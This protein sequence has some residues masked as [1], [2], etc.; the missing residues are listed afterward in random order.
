MTEAILSCLLEKSLYAPQQVI[1]SDIS[2]QRLRTLQETYGIQVVEE[3]SVVFAL[4]KTIV[5]GIKPQALITLAQDVADQNISDALIISILAGVPL[6]RLE[7][8]FSRCPVI[9]VM[10]NTP[11]RVG[12]GISAIAGGTLVQDE[13]LSHAV[14]A[15]SGSGPAF[16]A[17][18]IE[19]LTD[20]GVAVG[21]PRP[22]AAQLALQT[23]RGTAELMVQQ[24]IHPALMKDQVTSPGGTT[25]AGVSTLEAAGFRSALI[26]AV[27]SAYQRPRWSVVG[28]MLPIE[29][30]SIPLTPPRNTA[31]PLPKLAVLLAAGSLSSATGA[32]IAPV[33]PEVIADLQVDPGW[34]GLLVSIHTLTT[35]LASPVFAL[36]ANR[37]GQGV[38]L[39]LSLVG[40]ACFGVAG[41]WM[42]SFG[43]MLA[44]RALVGMASG[45]IAAVSI[46]ILSSM[47]EGDARSRMLGY[48]TSAL[49]VATVIFPVLSG[50][51]GSAHWQYS[52]YLH[53]LALL[54]AISAMFIRWR[55]AATGSAKSDAYQTHGLL[56]SLQQGSTPSLLGGLLLT[57]AIFYV[58][59][60]YVPLHLKQVINATP[61]VSG[62]VIA[63]QAVGAAVI[64]AVGASRLAKRIGSNPAIALGFLL[65]ASSLLILPSLRIPGLLVLAAL[66]FGIGVGLAMPSFYG[67][68]SNGTPAHQR[69]SILAIGTGVSSLGHFISPL[70]FGPVWKFLGE[71]V[72]TVAA[73][74]AIGLSILLFWQNQPKQ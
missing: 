71:T 68:L 69:S 2:P 16:V 11:A 30:K 13:H 33:F 43:S 42:D 49:A 65:M 59:I 25:I 34:A 40:Y 57:S 41:A 36:L 18:A 6:Q 39:G 7:S 67:A 10:P 64:S 50:W 74:L 47:Y 52:F 61:L 22:V 8:I 73:G 38:T 32:M 29:Q 66:P 15:L 27:Q 31:S 28:S 55:D 20:G 4:A 62:G 54:V 58:M 9:R 51:I 14:T 1:V 45:G 72:F 56:Q 12:A 23:V 17:I 37:I 24:Q 63:T 46:G 44:A 60:V 5:L 53:G 70:L 35:A 48:A 3:N 19:A 26:Q 21:L